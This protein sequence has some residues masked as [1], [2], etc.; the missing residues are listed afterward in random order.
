MKDILPG[1]LIT[2]CPQ[3]IQSVSCGRD[4]GGQPIHDVRLESTCAHGN[5][6]CYDACAVMVG[7]FFSLSYVFIFSRIQFG[8]A[9]VVFFSLFAKYF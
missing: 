6:V 7:M 4:D 9:K 3:M 2:I 5:H 1:I 8:S